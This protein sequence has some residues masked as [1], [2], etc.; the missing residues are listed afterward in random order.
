MP[1]FQITVRRGANATYD[2]IAEYTDDGALL[3]VRA[4]ACCSIDEEQLRILNADPIG[5]GTALGQV[6]FQVNLRDAFTEAL[7]G[8]RDSPLRVLLFVDEPSL[9]RLRWERLCVPVD[10]KWRQLAT[11]QRTP[12]SHYLPSLTDRRF[13]PLGRADMRALLVCASPPGLTGFGLG[14]FDEE[15]ALAGV[16]SALGGT[17]ITVL[18]GAPGADGPPTLA[19]LSRRLTSEPYPLLH[20]VC[21]GRSL[22]DGESVIYL[23][24]DDDTRE[25]D[26][27]TAT[28]LIERLSSLQGSGGLPHLAFLSTCE[29]AIPAASGAMGGLAHRLVR[30]LG[31]PAVVAM[32]DKIS[33]DT[34][35]ALAEG[36]YRRLL[37]PEHGHP[38]RAL[39]EATAGLAERDDICVPALFSRLGERRLFDENVDSPLNPRELIRG[40]E[41]L[42][43]CLAERAP[44]L[45]GDLVEAGE[46]LRRPINPADPAARSAYDAA[47]ARVEQ[48]CSEATERSFAALAR[49]AEL[50]PY[51]VR[52]PFPGLAP[53]REDDQAFFFGR[54]AVV[55]EMA[56]WLDQQPCLVVIG[57]SGSGKSSLVRAGLLPELQRRSPGLR[58]AW[59]TPGEMPLA[60]LTFAIEDQRR[61]AVEEGD[62][63]APIAVLIDQLEELFTLCTSEEERTAFIDQLIVLPQSHR[64]VLA[65]RS[66]FLG[67]C[68][69]YKALNNLL[70]PN[71]EQI[72]PLTPDELR[73]AIEKQAAAVGLRFEAG[74]SGKILDDV[75]DEPGAMP[76]LQ[77]A[78][79]EL[80]RRRRGRWLRAA[81]YA[82][83]GGIQQAISHTADQIYTAASPEERVRLRDIFLRLT[84][85]DQDDHSDVR[86]DTR[87]RVA[88]GELVPAGASRTQTQA[89][90]DRLVAS[91]LVV[92][93]AVHTYGVEDPDSAAARDA[94][95]VEV[96]HEALIRYWP[97]LRNWLSEDRSALMLRAAIRRDLQ[98][99]LQRGRDPDSLLRGSKLEE[100]LRLLELPRLQL[101]AEERGFIQASA[102]ERDRALAALEAERQAALNQARKLAEEQQARAEEQQARAEEAARFLARQR[103]LTNFLRVLAAFSVMAVIASGFL[104]TRAEQLRANAEIER[105]RAENERQRAETTAGEALLDRQ[106][107]EEQQATAVAERQRADAAA[108]AAYQRA[109][110]AAAES[111]FGEGDTEHALAYA[112]AALDLDSKDTESQ[113]LLAQIA[114]A[115]GTRL[116]LRGHFGAV[117]AVAFNPNRKIGVSGGE[118]GVVLLWNLETGVLMD[119]Y[120]GLED[121]AVSSLAFAPE[122]DNFAAGRVDGSITL[123]SLSRARPFAS[124]VAGAVTD[125]AFTIDG[126]RL[127]S[128]HDDGQ[129]LIWDTESRQPTEIR[130]SHPAAVSALALDSAGVRAITASVDGSLRVWDLESGAELL[131]LGGPEADGPAPPLRSLAINA[132]GS[133]AYT[134]GDDGPISVWDLGGANATPIA[135]LRGHTGGVLDLSIAPIGNRLVSVSW[136]STMRVWNLD[137]MRE[138]RRFIGHSSRVR[139]VALSAGG[140]QALS[141][142]DDGTMRLWDLNSR[143]EDARYQLNSPLEA[144][145]V[146]K[147]S[148]RYYTVERGGRVS[149]WDAQVGSRRELFAGGG[150]SAAGG[151]A[152]S[153]VTNLGASGFGEGEIRLWDISVDPPVEV[154]RLSGHRVPVHSLAFSPDGSRLVSGGDDGTVIYWDVESGAELN[155]RTLRGRA[156]NALVFAAGGTRVAIAATDRIVRIWDPAANIIMAEFT[157]HSGQVL[158]L[159]ASP[160][161][162]TVASGSLDRSIWLWQVM[163]GR[164][165]RKVGEHGGGVLGLAFIDAERLVSS[166]FDG[167][168]RLWEVESGA[169]LRRYSLG[170]GAATAVAATV[171]AGSAGPQLLAGSS[172]GVMLRWNI[173]DPEALK[174][175]IKEN[176]YV[177]ALPND[178]RFHIR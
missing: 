108:N 129:V 153:Y 66:D 143:S 91:R 106:R 170:S 39:V 17:P 55:N 82:A 164:G 173:D 48:I 10:G 81:E 67:E 61:K 32:S 59:C 11:F 105:Q 19:E 70:I 20:I 121:T 154:G 3:P 89:L 13:P 31:L 87:Q 139:S 161:G 71:I 149:S 8:S 110:R 29:S 65:M 63:D 53:F 175:W 56:N 69:K 34:A 15:R 26:P 58:V 159:V 5:Y 120:G 134:G 25:V 12:F 125:L 2:L 45:V 94:V 27:I 162:T 137:N 132:E 49:G 101:N 73:S 93:G 113:R 131:R 35:N 51:D 150:G 99:W 172:E 146:A 23:A 122:G 22:P 117:S 130:L 28:R 92:T 160:D 169:E 41:R 100:A 148:K 83:I 95:P 97:R 80:W 116:L 33:V 44:I 114:D 147:D 9:A 138:E 84:R 158:S 36:F 75:R 6:I 1:I 96:A 168:V 155:R 126:S 24:R 21:H 124:R 60:N 123:Y 74:L 163:D 140:E 167:T 79:H 178:E 16:R 47:R 57:P 152:I 54:E 151:L 30:E 157:G 37:A 166:S 174:R 109:L 64:T 88:F 86:R 136:D 135:S 40:L 142:A 104:F 128:A 103:R 133:L 14:H 112:M 4:E 68:G 85:V 78:L 72:G 46:I 102:V 127:I 111:D 165:I 119:R 42:S 177:P 171:G 18:R 50:P 115:P 145:A 141:G 77:H 118:D 76:L 52:C 38:D 7:R 107:A 176:R 90:I 156:I 62:P 43:A 98:D 144:I